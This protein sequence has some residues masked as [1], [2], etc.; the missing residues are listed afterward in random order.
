MLSRLSD[1]AKGVNTVLHELS[2]EGDEQPD[3]TPEAVSNINHMEPVLEAEVP[4]DV[5]ERLA[6]TE[7]LVGQLKELIREKDLQLQSNEAAHKG[8][9][10]VA[11]ARLAK[12]KLQAKGR[13]SALTGRI[14]ELQSGTAHST[15]SPTATPPSP[16]PE[17]AEHSPAQVTT[18]QCV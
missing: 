1:I 15:T 9:R 6:H 10:E 7:Q 12:L 17:S 14:E 18:P 16:E 2:G 3:S 4:E 5:L 11:E 13:I 8:E